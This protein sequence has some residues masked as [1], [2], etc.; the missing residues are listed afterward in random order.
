MPIPKMWL[1]PPFPTIMATTQDATITCG[2]ESRDCFDRNH[3]LMDI[4]PPSQR[5]NGPYW[6]FLGRW[7]ENLAEF[8]FTSALTRACCCVDPGVHLEVQLRRKQHTAVRS[9]LM[10]SLDYRGAASVIEATIKDVGDGGYVMLQDEEPC[11]VPPTTLPETTPASGVDASTSTSV[12]AA[13]DTAIAWASTAAPVPGVPDLNTIPNAADV[14]FE[15][16][17]LMAEMVS[18]VSGTPLVTPVERTIT[19][20]RGEFTAVPAVETPVARRGMRAVRFVPRF[21]AS[22]VVELRSR[23]GQLG[24]EVPGNKLIIE[25]EAIRLM[26]K[27]KVRETDAVAHLPSIIGCYFAEDIHYRVETSVGR[28]SRFQ[29]WL[30]SEQS[31]ST[32]TYGPLA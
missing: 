25:R 28:M 9:A 2:P 7:K 1:F 17:S 18:E 20:R 15:V 30:A 22:V 16:V 32:P 23:L 26:R 29:R 31:L 11:A 4:L 19:P 24:S 14:P 13:T 8:W 5:E 6:T 21:A 3:E 27:Y 12:D 10:Y